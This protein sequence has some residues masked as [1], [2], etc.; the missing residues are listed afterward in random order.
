MKRIFLDANIWLR[1]YL[2]DNI[3][4]LNAVKEL[5]AVVET[6]LLRP[7]TSTIVFLEVNYVLR[8]FYKLPVEKTLIYLDKMKGVRNISILE[9]TNL[10]RALT[11]YR[12]YKI[13]FSD[14]LIAAQVPVGMILTSFDREFER[15]QEIQ[16]ATPQDII[17]S[18]SHES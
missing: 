16:V 4:H 13:K 11:Y 9:T 3:E 2:A 17:T 12:R 10:E 18:L 15:I 8:S 1:L 7:Y 6:G 14:C 5:L